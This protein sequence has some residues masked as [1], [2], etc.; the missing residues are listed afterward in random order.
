[1]QEEFKCLSPSWV[2]G[3]HGFLL[4]FNLCDSASLTSCGTYFAMIKKEA[5]QK[6]RTIPSLVVVGN[7]ADMPDKRRVT[8]A[9]AQEAATEW[10]AGYVETSARTGYNVD[11]AFED[12]IRL[13]RRVT[14][15]DPNKKPTKRICVLI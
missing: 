6:G 10:G 12:L 7:K 4:V 8:S 11:K 1:M 14:D 15:A 9:Q 5:E 13:I 3:K 2:E